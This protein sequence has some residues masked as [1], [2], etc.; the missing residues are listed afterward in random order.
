[1][2]LITG[3]FKNGVLTTVS[4]TRKTGVGLIARMAWVRSG[5]PQKVYRTRSWS[6]SRRNGLKLQPRRDVADFL[7][8]VATCVAG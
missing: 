8:I 5:A 3:K 4:T 1:M 7:V 6:K 2:S